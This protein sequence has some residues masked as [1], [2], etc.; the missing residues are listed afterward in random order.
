MY[1]WAFR[2]ILLMLYR[3]E[4]IKT[5]AKLLQHCCVSISGQVGY[6]SRHFLLIQ[7]NTHTHNCRCV[8]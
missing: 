1:I 3:I 4:H 7:N 8:V 6:I 5:Q 2:N